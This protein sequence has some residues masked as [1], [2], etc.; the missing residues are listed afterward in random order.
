LALAAVEPFAV[1]VFFLATW[2]PE[3]PEEKELAQAR[4][5]PPAKGRQQ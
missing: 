1:L 3:S 2:A 4:A 5:G